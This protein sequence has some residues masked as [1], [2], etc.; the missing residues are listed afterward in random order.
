[1]R[2]ALAAK[3]LQYKSTAVAL[4]PGD[5]KKEAHTARNPM[6]QVPCLALR[7]QGKEVHLAQSLPIIEFLEDAFPNRP[8]LLPRDPMARAVAREIAEIVNSGTQPLQN[9]SVCKKISA[10][11]NGSM[12]GRAFGADMIKIGL[13][14]VEKVRE[15]RGCT[16]PFSVGA[17]PTIADACLIPQLYNARRFNV[18]LAAVCPSLLE[19]EQAC[20]EHPWFVQA[21]PDNQPDAVVDTAAPPAKKA[22]K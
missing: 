17:V 19:V 13:Q 15:L 7:D 11:S 8:S 14:A 16:G 20:A 1:M 2:V 3:G 5:Q 12:D 4:L 21:H 22:K 6:Q 18:D 9:L 10:D